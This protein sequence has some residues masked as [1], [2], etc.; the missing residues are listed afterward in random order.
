MTS[1]KFGVQDEKIVADY[2]QHLKW[3][4]FQRTKNDFLPFLPIETILP[5][6]TSSYLYSVLRKL[7]KGGNMHTHES[8]I[9]QGLNMNDGF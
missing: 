1:R 9:E 5:N 7:P 6:I 8:K 4:E 3:Q 2:L